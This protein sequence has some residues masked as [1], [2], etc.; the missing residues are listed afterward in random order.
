[1]LLVIAGW[2]TDDQTLVRNGENQYGTVPSTALCIGLLFLGL[3][4]TTRS[5]H[6]ARP[7]AIGAALT[8]AAVAMGS[9]MLLQVAAEGLDD[10]VA[11][12]SRDFMSPATSVGIMFASLTLM[13]SLGPASRAA[14]CL[15]AVLGLSVFVG[16]SLPN[17]FVV[18]SIFNLPGLQGMS[19][20]T[21]VA[22]SMFFLNQLLWIDAHPA[23]AALEA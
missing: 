14:G 10:P 9:Q 19:F 6:R 3:G 7:V 2:L 1:M 15:L 12:S 8:A 11:L 18:G 13:L 16:I 17:P 20:Y 4:L 5:W 22:L 23:D 21:A